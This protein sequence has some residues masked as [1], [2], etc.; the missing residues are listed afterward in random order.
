MDDLMKEIKHKP[1]L[2][3][4]PDSLIEKTLKDYLSKNHLSIGQSPKER[5]LI[6]KE[7]RAQLRKY[8]GQYTSK[9]NIENRKRLIEKGRFSELLN[10][11]ASTRE[12]SIDYEEIK[13]IINNLNAKSILDL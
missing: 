13:D 2:K 4:L 11:H 6:I 12:R 10:E 1:E 3:D 9:S 5:K 7:V 8:A